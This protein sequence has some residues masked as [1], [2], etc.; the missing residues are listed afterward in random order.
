MTAINQQ[1]LDILNEGEQLDAR[2]QGQEVCVVCGCVFEL[3]KTVMTHPWA[4]EGA[5]GEAR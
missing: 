1:K 5:G 3:E 4:A 2:E